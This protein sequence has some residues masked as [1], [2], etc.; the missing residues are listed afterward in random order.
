MDVCF[1]CKDCTKFTLNPSKRSS[2]PKNPTEPEIYTL[3]DLSFKE[4]VLLNFDFELIKSFYYLFH[5]EILF[6]YFL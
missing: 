3:L 1:P 5:D 6:N 4:V 2:H